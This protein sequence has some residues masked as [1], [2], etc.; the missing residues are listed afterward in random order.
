MAVNVAHRH[1]TQGVKRCEKRMKAGGLRRR[2]YCGSRLLAH[3]VRP[4]DESAAVLPRGLRP[5]TCSKHM[6][7]TSLFPSTSRTY[8]A[9]DGGSV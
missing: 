4:L 6:R 2:K 1:G 7:S 9:Q 3:I 8:T 5:I